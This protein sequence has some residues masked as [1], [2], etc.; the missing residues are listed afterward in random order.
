M[1]VVIDDGNNR[2]A[3][4]MQ[5]IQQQQARRREDEA[6]RQQEEALRRSALARQ[7]G[8]LAPEQRT[9]AYSALPEDVRPWII[10]PSSTPM[11]AQDLLAKTTAEKTLGVVNGFQPDQFQSGYIAT[12]QMLGRNPNAQFTETLRD[13]S[14]MSPD[15][16]Q[17]Y[18]NEGS[19]PPSQAEQNRAAAAESNADAAFTSGPKTAT[20]L[21]QAGKYRAETANVGKAGAGAVG[22]KHAPVGISGNVDVSGFPASVAAAGED[23]MRGG[24]ITRVP[25]QSRMA[26]FEYVAKRGGKAL[27]NDVAKQLRGQVSAETSIDEISNA[28]EKY[29]AAKTPGEIAK[30]AVNLRA[31]VYGSIPLLA[32]G[33]G[34]TGVL[35]QQDVDSVAASILGAK[36]AAGLALAKSMPGETR[37]RINGMR[38]Q[39]AEI[40]RRL[41][42]DLIPQGGGGGGAKTVTRAELQR[43]GSTPEEAAAAG[44]QVVN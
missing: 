6:M 9:T 22:G 29:A 20:E 4:V 3:A 10:D 21:A 15:A 1:P 37:Q 13:S 19:I 32:R 41:L 12:E 44:Y 31:K 23:V 26:V 36:G 30:E 8:D 28:F 7:Y 17:T 5:Y 2:L 33:I 38:G 11:T 43:M 34:H 42:E 24:D 18:T 40:Q 14:Y 16:F 39:F 27:P 35:T 25:F